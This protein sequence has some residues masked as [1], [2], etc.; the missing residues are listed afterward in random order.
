M[1]WFNPSQTFRQAAKATWQWNLA[2]TGIQT[3]LF[4]TFFLLVC[5]LVIVQLEDWIGISKFQF[6]YQVFAGW[7]LFGVAGCLGLTSGVTMAL[8]GK[9]TP[10]PT[11]CPRELVVAGPYAYLRNPMALAG[12]TQGVAVG[13]MLGSW[14][15]CLFSLAGALFWNLFVRPVEEQHLEQQFGESFRHYRQQVPCWSIRPRPYKPHRE[16]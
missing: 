16:R 15:V 1:S 12:I 6:P 11:D 8:V 9:G 5:P 10:L 3:V 13:L 2:K 4:W 7:S 14:S